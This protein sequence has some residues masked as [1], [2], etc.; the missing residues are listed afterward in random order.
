MWVDPVSRATEPGEANDLGCV[1]SEGASHQPIVGLLHAQQH[2][3]GAGQAQQQVQRETIELSDFRPWRPAKSRSAFFFSFRRLSGRP[4]PATG[5][6]LAG[7]TPS[8]LSRCF[9]DLYED[10]GRHIRCSTVIAA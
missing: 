6:F 10:K 1:L 7:D 4:L 9:S 2:I 3:A 8:G 5:L